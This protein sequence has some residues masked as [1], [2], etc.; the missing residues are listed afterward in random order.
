M[1]FRLCSAVDPGRRVRHDERKRVDQR[2]IA[3]GLIPLYEQVPRRYR[4]RVKECLDPYIPIAAK[5]LRISV[6]LTPHAHVDEAGYCAT[7]SRLL[8][9]HIKRVHA[10]SNGKERRHLTWLDSPKLTDEVYATQEASFVRNDFTSDTFAVELSH[11]IGGYVRARKLGHET[12]KRLKADYATALGN[13]LGSA[14]RATLWHG[15]E[16]Q[17][18]RGIKE[19]HFCLLGTAIANMENDFALLH[20][21]FPFILRNPPFAWSP[22]KLRNMLRFC[23]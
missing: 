17:V 6:A 18:W 11:A 1:D 3:Q 23:A 13:E 16:D 20:D 15:Y 2:E 14:F 12:A 22:N 4:D 5:D 8:G 9:R 21:F 7:L 10:I 19:F